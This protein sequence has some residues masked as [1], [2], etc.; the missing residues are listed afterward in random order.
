MQLLVAAGVDLKAAT[1]K[2]FFTPLHE[3]S[4]EGHAEAMALLIQAGANL[5]ARTSAVASSCVGWP[6][7]SACLLV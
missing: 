4:S 7:V 5:E 6:A 3:A 2:G 1:S